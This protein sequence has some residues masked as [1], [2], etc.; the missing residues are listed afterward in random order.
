MPPTHRESTHSSH[1]QGCKYE[2]KYKYK[3]KSFKTHEYF[4]GNCDY[5]DDD[6]D[7]EDEACIRRIFQRTPWLPH[8]A[9]EIREK[10]GE[11]LEI[12]TLKSW[13]RKPSKRS[14]PQPFTVSSFILQVSQLDS[15]RSFGTLPLFQQDIWLQNKILDYIAQE[16]IRW[17]LIIIKYKITIISLSERP[18]CAAIQHRHTV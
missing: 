11:T 2:Y 8:Q 7:A 5:D 12:Q 10:S 13:N 4:I 15:Q 9:V 16:N 6:V 14:P 17:Y 3:Y 18:G 1:R